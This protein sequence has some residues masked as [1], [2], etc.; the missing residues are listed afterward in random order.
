MV[1]Q[2]GGRFV[3]GGAGVGGPP[4]PPHRCDAGARGWSEFGLYGVVSTI[5]SKAT[6]T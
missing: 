5:S 3:G 4:E 1:R 6:D 2:E